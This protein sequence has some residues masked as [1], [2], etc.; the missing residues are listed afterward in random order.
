MTDTRR[1]LLQGLAL[2]PIAGAVA[3]L[4]PPQADAAPSDPSWTALHARYVRATAD[5]LTAVDEQDRAEAALAQRR[6]AATV[7][8][9]AASYREACRTGRRA[10]RLSEAAAM[11]AATDWP[12]LRLKLAMAGGD[13]NGGGA[14]LDVLS[15]D[16][17]PQHWQRLVSEIHAVMRNAR[18]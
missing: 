3:L 9:E 1:A 12:A 7:D 4:A 6:C 2:A 5:Y 13:H 11:K 8:A 15:C 14:G 18:A 10:R 16:L 17:R